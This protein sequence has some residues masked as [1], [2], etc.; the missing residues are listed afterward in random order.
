MYII[1]NSPTIQKKQHKHNYAIGAIPKK[2][3]KY[4]EWALSFAAVWSL[5]TTLMTSGRNTA[6]I[7]QLP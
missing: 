4:F 7:N 1:N 6:I 2:E 5:P 3:V